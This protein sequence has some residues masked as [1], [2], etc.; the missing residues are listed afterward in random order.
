MRISNVCYAKLFNLGNYENERIELEAQLDPGD[1]YGAA[2]QDL[3]AHVQRL[4]IIRADERG[5]DRDAAY[6][7]HG[8]KARLERIE[9][10]IKVAQG[11][12]ERAKEL[13]RKH[14]VDSAD[15]EADDDIPF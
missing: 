9:A 1:D 7:E 13:L 10:D 2:V 15:L 3:A 5:A 6:K 12:W 14:G 11:R 4:G 8:A